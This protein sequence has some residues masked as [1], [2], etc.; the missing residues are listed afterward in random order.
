[1]LILS[2]YH[3]KRANVYLPEHNM[4][5]FFCSYSVQQQSVLAKPDG[6]GGEGGH[7]H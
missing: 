7:N 4:I 2:A 6:C 1:M 5:L 3:R